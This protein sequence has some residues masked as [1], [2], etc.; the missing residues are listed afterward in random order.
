M[1]KMKIFKYIRD[2][3]NYKILNKLTLRIINV[4]ESF[5]GFGKHG[6]INKAEFKKLAND[7]EPFN[8]GISF[9]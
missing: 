7:L 6:Q 5:E 1:K 4:H 3:K 8:D 2:N 9:S